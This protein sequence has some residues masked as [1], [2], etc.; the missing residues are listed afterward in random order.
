MA[1]RSVVLL[2]GAQRWR[3]WVALG[4]SREASRALRGLHRRALSH[5]RDRLLGGAWH[6]WTLRNALTQGASRHRPN[7]NPN[8]NPQP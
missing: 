3:G 5:A 1:R 6:E 4:A 8:P 7:P 2:L